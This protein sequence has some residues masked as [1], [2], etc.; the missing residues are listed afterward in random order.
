VLSL[1][2]QLQAK[3]LIIFCIYYSTT[4]VILIMLIS[5]MYPVIKTKKYSL[6]DKL[7]LLY[8][9]YSNILS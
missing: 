1:L 8:Y 4:I 7:I 2:F 6:Y 9:Y 5:R 3:V